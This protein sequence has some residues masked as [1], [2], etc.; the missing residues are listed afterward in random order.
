MQRS[1]EILSGW[2]QQKIKRRAYA[3]VSPRT[4]RSRHAPPTIFDADI[5]GFLLDSSQDATMPS[6][7]VPSSLISP[8]SIVSSV[9]SRGKRNSP[10][11]KQI[12]V[13]NS[14]PSSMAS[15]ASHS[16]SSPRISR[17]SPPIFGRG[18]SIERKLAGGGDS[19]SSVLSEGSMN[20]DVKDVYVDRMLDAYD[21]KE[22]SYEDMVN[23]CSA[24]FIAGTHTTAGNI[25][26]AILHLAKCPKV[27]E[28]LYD[29]LCRVFPDG[30][31]S[32]KKLKE[33]HLLRA[34]IYEVLLV[35]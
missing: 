10:K 26:L 18:R 5:N 14:S 22:I 24:A 31:F 2:I 12:I 1:R 32:L 8:S 25:T 19:V 21:A 3:R 23:D 4:H 17:E 13:L 35:P 15:N 34:V 16:P 9:E 11:P 29:E 7:H 27:Q 33:L 20:I 6:S 30:E 28:R